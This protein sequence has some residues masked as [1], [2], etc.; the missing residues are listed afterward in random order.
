MVLFGLLLTGC[1]KSSSSSSGSSTPSG[2]T[3]AAPSAKFVAKTSGSPASLLEHLRKLETRYQNADQVDLE[4]SRAN[5]REFSRAVEGTADAIL[6]LPNPPKEIRMQGVG[7]K[8]ASLEMRIELDPKAFDQLLAFADTLEKEEP[9]S[10]FAKRAA[11]ERFRSIT[12]LCEGVY[13]DPRVRLQ[14]AIEA[15]L[16]FARFDPVT[17]EALPMLMEHAMRAETSDLPKEAEAIYRCVAERYPNEP[18][19]KFAEGAAYRVSQRGKVLEGIAGKDFD[20]KAVKLEDLR[21]KIVMIDFWASWCAPCMKEMD[22]LREMHH[23]LKPMNFEILG[24]CLDEDPRQGEYAIAK[25]KMDWPQIYDKNEGGTP[26][27]ALAM[28]FG[29]DRIPIKLL[30]DPE[31]KLV[32]SG[33]NAESL[34]QPLRNQLAQVIVKKSEEQKKAQAAEKAKAAGKSGQSKD[35][36]PASKPAEPQPEAPAAK[37]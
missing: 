15:I 22:T 32:S 8:L 23:V 26:N 20:G 17:P 31:G 2:S 19:V 1:Q 25:T 21:G 13:P 27:S 28:R 9:N 14:K 35:S 34:Q 3:T 11:F 37:K 5:R 4:V 29:I 10:E 6:A 12:E 36:E 33:F 18:L 24:I 7:A 16:R 30:I